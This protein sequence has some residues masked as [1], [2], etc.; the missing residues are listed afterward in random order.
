M[1]RFD[2]YVHPAHGYEA[3]K[4]GF[5]WP[6]FFFGV[7]WAF[8]KKLWLV[9]TVYLLAIV[10]L[11]LPA[12]DLE[13]GSVTTLYDFVGFAISLLVGV[14]GNGWRRQALPQQG[15]RFVDAVEAHSPREAVEALLDPRRP[16]VTV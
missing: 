10:L 3:V 11:A 9:G 15:Y 8:Y 6:A 16:G 12:D 13:S 1:S 14:T 4:H 2:V 5:S 7:I